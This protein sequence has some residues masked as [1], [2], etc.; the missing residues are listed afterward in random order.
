LIKEI[1]E[2]LDDQDQEDAC[3]RDDRRRPGVQSP[4]FF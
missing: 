4:G 3:A 1:I 2:K